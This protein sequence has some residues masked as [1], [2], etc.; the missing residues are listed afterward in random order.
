MEHLSP[1]TKLKMLEFYERERASKIY[2]WYKHGFISQTWITDRDL[3]VKDIYVNPD[4][5]KTG[6]AREMWYQ[7]LNYLISNDLIDTIL[8]GAQLGLT[9]SENSISVLLSAGFSLSHI[10]R[11]KNYAYYVLNKKE[12]EKWLQKNM[13]KDS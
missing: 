7:H 5:R 2:F 12:G 10:N 11:P 3:Y 13:K 8:G 6:Y 4:K 9:S 1:S